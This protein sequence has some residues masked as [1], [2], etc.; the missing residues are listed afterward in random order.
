M[1]VKDLGVVSLYDLTWE[2]VYHIKQ[3]EEPSIH[4]FTA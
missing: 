1:C 3:K 2:D 4:Y